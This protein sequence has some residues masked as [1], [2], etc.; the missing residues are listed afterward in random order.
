MS[1][2][3]RIEHFDFEVQKMLQG[4]QLPRTKFKKNL[5]VNFIGSFLLIWG[6][7]VWSLLGNP[8]LVN[9]PSLQVHS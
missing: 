1:F 8:V 6:H 2:R 4:G 5:V 7:V 9:S 3:S